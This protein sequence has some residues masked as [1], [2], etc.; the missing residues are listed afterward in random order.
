MMVPENKDVV[1][2]YNSIVQ[3]ISINSPQFYYCH[4]ANY[5]NDKESTRLLFF[6][7]IK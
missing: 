2:L 3:D 1:D 4:L 6:L 7:I 5:A